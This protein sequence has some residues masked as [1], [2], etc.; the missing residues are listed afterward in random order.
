MS[1]T[2]SRKQ[3]LSLLGAAA[4]ALAL[5]LA[6]RHG[7]P[8][9]VACAWRAGWGAGARFPAAGKARHLALRLDARGLA[10]EA[11]GRLVRVRLP[12]DPVA[13]GAAAERAAGAAS[14]PVVV[15]LA[16]PRE[17]ALDQ[18][19]AAQDL[20]VLVHRPDSDDDALARAA[21]AS[22]AGLRVPIVACQLAGAG[23][24]RALASSGLAA[25]PTLRHAL[26][27]ALEAVG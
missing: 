14:C 10:A 4:P 23:P 1:R 3:F 24:L 25:P 8:C 17:P 19:L 11:A 2:L 9:G 18:L 26:T 6:R 12:D 5:A 7:A 27:P 21:E 22:L 20:V 16:G 15:A 13:A